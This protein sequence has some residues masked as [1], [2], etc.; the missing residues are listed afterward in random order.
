MTVL[1]ASR[2]T[3]L[4]HDAFEGAQFDGY[5]DKQSVHGFRSCLSTIVNETMHYRP[6]AVAKQLAHGLVDAVAAAYN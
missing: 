4:R 1:A 5:K 3:Y 2:E 6:A